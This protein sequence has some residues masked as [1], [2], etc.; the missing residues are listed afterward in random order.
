MYRRPLAR[1]A[2]CSRARTGP[3]SNQG[4]YASHGHAIAANAANIFKQCYRD[5][6][7]LDSESYTVYTNRPTAGAMRGYGIPAG[8]ASSPKR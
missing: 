1:M 4:G 6:M 8:A 7:S 3:W 5:R 2:R